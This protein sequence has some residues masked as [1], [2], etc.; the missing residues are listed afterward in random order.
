[1]PD[2]EKPAT[3]ADLETAIGH[4]FT[5]ME[6]F[7]LKREIELYWRFLALGLVLLGAQ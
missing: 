7:V 3:K 1:M 2:E 6:K 4:A 5:R